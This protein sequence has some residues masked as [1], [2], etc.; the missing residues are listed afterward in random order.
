[1]LSVGREQTLEEQLAALDQRGLDSGSVVASGA[2]LGPLGAAEELWDQ[3][4]PQVQ[5]ATEEGAAQLEQERQRLR[6]AIQ[7]RDAEAKRRGEA[8]AVQAA[9]IAAEQE[10]A[11]QREQAL[12]KAEQKK[13]IADY[14][15]N[16][17]KIRAASPNFCSRSATTR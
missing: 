6:L 14:R 11:K 2:M 7:Q 10:I 17:E 13:A 12:T 1:M 5:G 8:A 15:A 9:A 4:T 3:I 16:V